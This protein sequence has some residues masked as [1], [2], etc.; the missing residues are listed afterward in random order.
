MERFVQYLDDLDDLVYAIALIWERIRTLCNL[1]VTLTAII[2]LQA[3]SIYFA[4]T[5]PPLTVAMASLLIVVLL[6]RSVVYHG[7]D[8]Q[9]VE[10]GAATA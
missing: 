7:P 10:K 1:T 5:E 6:Y 4:V 8:G 3:M 2:A 9:A